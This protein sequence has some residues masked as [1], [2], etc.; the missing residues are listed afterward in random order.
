MLIHVRGESCEDVL[1]IKTF[2]TTCVFLRPFHSS[3]TLFVNQ[4]EEALPQCNPERQGLLARSIWVSTLVGGLG[5]EASR[6][7]GSLCGGGRHASGW[8]G[9]GGRQVDRW[10]GN[11]GRHDTEQPRG[12]SR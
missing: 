9:G 1:Q 12:R 8:P 11:G 10:L 5:I 4:A 3:N 2:T 7:V 6:L